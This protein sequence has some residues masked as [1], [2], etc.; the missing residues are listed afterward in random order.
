MNKGIIAAVII[1]VLIGGYA[2]TQRGSTAPATGGD[3][4]GAAATVTPTG[5]I[6]EIAY[7]DNH[8]NP[9]TVT[10]HVGDT[11]RIENKHVANIRAASN[12]HPFHTSQPDFDSDTLAPGES[13]DYVLK[14]PGTI[15]FHN[16]FNPGEL[17]TITILP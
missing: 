6:I 12:P 8:W 11:I 4:S 13:W 9:A 3:T 1:V 14:A 15:G 17:G 7:Q 10:G 5:K 2:L 16:H